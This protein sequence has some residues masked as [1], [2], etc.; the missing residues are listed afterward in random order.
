M[1]AP[2]RLSTLLLS[3]LVIL[4]CSAT[5]IAADPV[6]VNARKVKWSAAP[7]ALPKGAQVAVLHGDPS[8]SGP[9]VLLLSMPTRYKIP[10]H[11][12]THDQNM[13]VISGTLFVA[14]TET[15]DRKIAVPVRAGGFV[16]VPAQAQQFSFTKGK[17][18]VEIQGTG[19]YDV[20]YTNPKDDPLMGAKG[21]MYYF[22][23]EYEKNE[24]NAPAAGE[25]IPTF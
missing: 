16:H 7:P 1:N 8:S 20:K 22:P 12:H 6:V 17:T 5:A 14:S 15:F 9:Y 23:K 10:F 18:V 24:L 19:P 11:W 2:C 21:E 4:T 13:T 25:P 3:G